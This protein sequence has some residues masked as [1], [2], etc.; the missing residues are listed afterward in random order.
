MT[1][2]KMSSL[3]LVNEPG[4]LWPSLVHVIRYTLLP[5]PGGGQDLQSRLG[6]RTGFQGNRSL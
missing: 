3:S 6:N 5:H 4:M 2:K 1:L